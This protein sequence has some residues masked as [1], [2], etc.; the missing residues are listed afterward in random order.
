MSWFYT[1]VKY[2]YRPIFRTFFLFSLL[3]LTQ[4]SA[5]F[6][7]MFVSLEN[8]NLEKIST[9]ISLTFTTNDGRLSCESK[10]SLLRCKLKKKPHPLALFREK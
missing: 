10:Y 8:K 2:V 6:C 3:V 9:L 4:T 7:K 5:Y 1:T